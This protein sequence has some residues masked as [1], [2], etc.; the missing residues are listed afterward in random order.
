MLINKNGRSNFIILLLGFAY[1]IIIGKLYYLSVYKYNEDIKNKFLFNNKK[2]VEIVDR[3]NVLLATDI[4]TYSLYLNNSLIENEQEIAK[5]FAPIL[6]MEYKI[7]YKK[8]KNRSKT[9][10]LILIKRNLTPEEQLQIKQIGI[11]STVFEPDSMRFYPHN[12]LFSH[13][14]GYTDIDKNGMTGLEEYYDKY[15]KK[16]ENQTLKLTMDIK[17]QSILREELIKYHQLYKTNFILAIVS[18]IDSGNIL[19]AVSIP[20]YNLNKVSTALPNEMYN[21]ISLGVFEMGSV[22]K[23]FTISDAF[24]TK[25]V[26]K[27][28]EINVAEEIR[29]GNFTIKDGSHIRKPIL[30]VEEGFALSSNKIM[31]KIV[32]RIGSKK[33]I[34]F[35]EQMG[36][37][38]K[39]NI[40]INQLGFPIQP[41]VFSDVNVATISYGYGLAISP[42][43]VVYGLNT[44]MNNGVANSLRFSYQKQQV[45]KT[46]F[47]KRITKL[48]KEMFIATI[49]KGTGKLAKVEGINIGGK[50]GTAEI[51][52]K[53]GY[54]KHNNRASFV[55]VFPIENPKYS[56]FI[57]LD[58]PKKDETNRAGTGGSVAAPIIS[59]MI[60]KMLPFLNNLQ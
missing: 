37:L 24:I 23:I 4:P 8:I 1:L 47:D 46:I 42:L 31:A 57:L 39:L 2:R 58:N 12:N 36:M 18:E 53:D 54:Q 60:T 29:Y 16:T 28:T 50:T 14:L 3:N 51:I 33:Y 30:T 10:N 13:I 19:G 38:E 20:D 40:D 56:V 26:N 9:A 27:D 45:Q 6:Q 41:R 21:N 17:I 32:Q 49:Q 59:T 25:V 43:H 22:M 52:S 5:L 55:A 11:A 35:L 34:N 48:M 15:L 44:I 7:L